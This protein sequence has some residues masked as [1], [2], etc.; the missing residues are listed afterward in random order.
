MER[1]GHRGIGTRR[2]GQSLIEADLSG[3]IWKIQVKAGQKVEAG[4]T[5]IIVEAMKMEIHVTAPASGMVHEIVCQTG[6]PV[7]SGDPL[8]VFTN[9]RNAC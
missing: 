3:N 7:S 2:G 6:R 5:L 8:I 4:E 9:E 1:R